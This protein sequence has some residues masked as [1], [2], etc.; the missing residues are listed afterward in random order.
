MK[1]RLQPYFSIAFAG[2]LAFAP[3]TFMLK[4][5]K[6]DIVAIEYPIN[7]FISQ[8]IR[9][10][11]IPYWFNTWGLGFPL[12]S[13]LTWGIFSTPQVFFSTL[14]DYSIYTLHLEFLF[15]VILAGWSMYFLLKTQFVN[16]RRTAQ[17]LA[18]G[19]MLIRIYYR[20]FA[21]ASLYFGCRHHSIGALCIPSTIKISQ[22]PECDCL[23]AML[24]AV[25]FTS[26]YTAF[27]IITTYGL[28]V[29]L[30]VFFFRSP[31][32]I[33]NKWLV[34][35]M[36]TVGTWRVILLCLPALYYTIELLPYLDRGTAL[37]TGSVFFN[38]NYLHPAL[39]K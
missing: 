29:Y 23:F 16:D 20:F 35:R 22:P 26:I 34:L 7:Y 17:I 31:L 33:K 12:Q 11:E 21:M 38:S 3:V 39:I 18:I 10:G 25:M 5:L 24:Y 14:F 15:F 2:L 13:N 28:I 36:V 4:A 1:A 30:I 27:S 6:N 19:Y 9:H 32:G 8:S 37:S